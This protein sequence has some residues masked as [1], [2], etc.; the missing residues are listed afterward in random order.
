MP[1]ANDP[2]DISDETIEEPIRPDDHL[3]IRK[4]WELWHLSTGM[5]EPFKA[6]QN[7]LRTTAEALCRLKIV[8]SDV[9]DRGEN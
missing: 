3:A 8:G 7:V 1:Y 2:G 9:S 5:R 4:V 6:P